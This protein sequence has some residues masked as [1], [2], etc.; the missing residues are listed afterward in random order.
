M[1]GNV[2]LMLCI[3]PLFLLMFSSYTEI[4]VS[5]TILTVVQC[6][7][8]RLKLNQTVKTLISEEFGSNILL[9]TIRERVFLNHG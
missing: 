2:S 4:S 6:D 3:S 5:I 1:G 7:K 9:V 8:Q